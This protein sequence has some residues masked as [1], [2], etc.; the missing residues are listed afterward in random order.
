MCSPRST[1]TVTDVFNLGQKW[2]CFGAS[3]HWLSQTQRKPQQLLTEAPPVDLLLPKPCHANP[4]QSYKNITISEEPNP[5]TELL[6]NT[7]VLKHQTKWRATVRNPSLCLI[8]QYPT[9]TSILWRVPVC[10]LCRRRSSPDL[11]SEKLTGSD[12]QSLHTVNL[13]S[14]LEGLPWGQVDHSSPS[15]T[16]ASFK[17]RKK[18]QN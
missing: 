7:D 14:K 4:R 6:S 1:A 17:I 16:L 12:T 15:G 2:V 3:W 18:Q 11:W 5:L 8:L 9:H 10:H 13:C